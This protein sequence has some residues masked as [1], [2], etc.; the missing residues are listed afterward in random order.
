MA[1]GSCHS[2]AHPID[3]DIF[4]RVSPG[5]WKEFLQPFLDAAGRKCHIVILVGLEREDRAP[6]TAGTLTAHLE[7]I[8]P[9]LR[10]GKIVAKDEPGVDGAEVELSRDLDEFFRIGE[11]FEV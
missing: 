4:D 5:S 10:I 7:E 2:L 6:Q 1:K 11:S 8:A 9:L 3:V